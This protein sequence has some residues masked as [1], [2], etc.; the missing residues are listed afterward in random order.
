MYRRRR[1]A[2]MAQGF[3]LVE[4]LVVIAI[5]G[6]LASLVGPRVIKRFGDA[7]ADAARLQI[8]D[9]G[10]GL[11][12]FFLDV[13]RYP[14]TTEGLEALVIDPGSIEGW[15]GPYLKKSA[16]PEDPWGQAFVYKAPGDH[17]PYDLS[18][19]GADGRTGGEGDAADVV[20]WE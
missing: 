4:L 19:A 7:K 6:L 14:S 20:S 17:G 3:T 11:D 18:S 12:V 8:A 2:G 13:G 5:L 9:L 10:A 1:V 16:V 15:N